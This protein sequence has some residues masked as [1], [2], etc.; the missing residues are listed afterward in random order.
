MNAARLRRDLGAGGFLNVPIEALVLLTR[1]RPEDVRSSCV[2]VIGGS[3]ALVR[4]VMRDAAAR[5]DPER[6][7]A[8]AGALAQNIK[9]ALV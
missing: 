5:P 2:P 4:H 7:R 8:L 1:G 6:A 3:D 9:L